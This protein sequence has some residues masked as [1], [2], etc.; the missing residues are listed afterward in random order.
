MAPSTL[1]ATAA[2][3]NGSAVTTNVTSTGTVNEINMTGTAPQLMIGPMSVPLSQ[4]SNV[5]N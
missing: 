4:V 2:G 1:T 5:T 3:S